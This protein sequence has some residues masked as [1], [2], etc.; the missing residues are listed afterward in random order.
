MA[1]FSETDLT[2]TKQGILLLFVLIMLL[3]LF[4]LVLPFAKETPLDGIDRPPPLPE[5]TPST[6]LNEE[7]Q[8]K[9]SPAFEQNIGFHPFLVR[10]R[11]Q[12]NYSVF[13]FSDI[14]D[15]VVGKEGY[16]FL[17]PYTDAVTGADFVGSEYIDIQT[18]KMKTLQ[19]ELKKKGIDFFVVLAPGKGSFYSEYIPD[20]IM[21]SAKPDSTNYNCYKKM[22]AE[23]KVNCLDLSAHFLSVKNTEKYPLYSTTGVHWTEYSCYL[24]SK[25]IVAYIENIRK[26]NLPDIKLESIEMLDLSGNHSSDYDAACLM[27]IF[28]TVPHPTYAIPKL[29]YV[30]DSS[31]TKPRFLCVADSYFAGITNTGV[32]S[33]VFADYQYWLYYDRIYQS[34]LKEKK[35]A[36]LNLKNEI[37]KKDVICLLATD[38]S[39]RPFPFG[40]VDMAYELFAK[41]DS[42]YYA[43]K[44]EEFHYKILNTIENIHKNKEWKASLVANA[45]RKNISEMDEFIENA[46]WAYKEEQ[47]RLKNE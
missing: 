46:L 17:K 12:I 37:E 33:N 47:L 13:G 24:A 32:P 11:N 19:T 36:E 8:K 14:A 15:V 18:K 42:A 1:R 20:K 30:S 7:Y 35:V 31:T 28:S 6:W 34:Y 4:Q 9:Y 27:N 16:L 22:F 29:Q 25:E 38:A 44:N 10:L 3:P 21:K 39:L 41:K 26:I 43:L 45:K 40:F 5:F 23:Q 2:K